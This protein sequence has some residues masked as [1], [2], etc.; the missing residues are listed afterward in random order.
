MTVTTDN[1]GVLIPAL[2]T[3]YGSGKAVSIS[4]KFAKGFSVANFTA[5]GA[6]I[7]GSLEVTI[8]VGSDTAVQAEFDL[9]SGAADINSH[10]GKVFGDI[11]KASLGSISTFTT[12]LGITKDAFLK[13]LQDQLDTGV[14]TANGIL[15]AGWAIPKIL[16]IDVSDVE[17][18]FTP[19]LMSV[20]LSVS[21]ATWEGVARVIPELKKSFIVAKKSATPE[22]ISLIQ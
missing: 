17:I 15:K 11:S 4:G 16:G 10:D 6:Q 7:Q 2:L 21:Q 19:G 9:I 18:N 5:A 20:G 8:G 3:K 22:S 13:G 12:T 14:Q 1:V